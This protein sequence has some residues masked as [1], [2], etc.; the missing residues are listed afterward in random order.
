M[1]PISIDPL[2]EVRQ[3]V[4]EIGFPIRSILD[5]PEYQL[6]WLAPAGMDWSEEGRPIARTEKLGLHSDTDMS[7]WA[8]EAPRALRAKPSAR[9]GAPG[10]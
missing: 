5:N 2:A 3:R 8:I 7:N 10:D 9:M 4:R 6:P 1:L